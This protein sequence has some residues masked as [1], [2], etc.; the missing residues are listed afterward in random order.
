MHDINNPRDPMAVAL[1]DFGRATGDLLA[2]WIKTL[3]TE[4][5]IAIEGLLGQGAQVGIRFLAATST[6]RPVLHVLLADPAGDFVTVA[7][8]AFER[9]TL[10]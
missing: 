10:Q 5:V 3:P 1:Y 2:S 8:V 4:Q 6:K 7:E 9:D